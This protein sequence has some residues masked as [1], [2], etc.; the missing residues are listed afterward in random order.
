MNSLSNEDY[1]DFAVQLK[2]K[3]RKSQYEAMKAVNVKL[4]NLY[5]G[6]G[7][8]I[9]VQQEEK[10]WGKSI[11]EVLAEE[12]KKEFPIVKGFSA[13]NFWRMRNFYIEYKNELILPP[14]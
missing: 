14:L 11:V 3:I 1:K 2:D 10:W 12:L 13:S 9:Y 5:W 7:K 4:I 6:F 8:G